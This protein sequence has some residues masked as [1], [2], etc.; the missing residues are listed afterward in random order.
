MRELGTTTLGWWLVGKSIS[1]ELIG[2]LN[3]IG[4]WLLG[5]PVPAA[6]A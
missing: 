6:P 5:V 4:L 2:M 1:M 3:G